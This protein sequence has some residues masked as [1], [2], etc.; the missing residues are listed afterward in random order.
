MTCYLLQPRDGMFVKGCGFLSFSKDMSKNN[1]RNIS[2]NLSSKYSL[3][4]M[5]NNLPQMHLKLPQKQSF[6]K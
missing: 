1:G 3:L 6:K 2:E 4:V 5:L